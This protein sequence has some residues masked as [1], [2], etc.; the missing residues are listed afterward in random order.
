MINDGI[1]QGVG[2]CARA[3]LHLVIGKLPLRNVQQNT[4]GFM[5][6][7]LFLPVYKQLLLPSA[8]CFLHLQIA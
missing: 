7:A 4:L 8:L 3:V 2:C 5:V 6:T 1:A